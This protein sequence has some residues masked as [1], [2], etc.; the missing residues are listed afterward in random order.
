M[1]KILTIVLSVLIFLAAAFIGVANV[2]RVDGVVLDAKTVSEEAKIEAKQMQVELE[3][4]Y[5]GESSLF[6]KNEAALAV[7]EKYPYFRLTK[8][9]KRYPD[10]LYVE[11]TEDP[12]V[13]A[14]EADGEYY[15]LSENGTVLD[16][17]EEKL[18]RADGQPNVIVKG[19]VPQGGIGD[20]VSGD[21]LSELL[22]MCSLMARNLNGVRSNVAEVRFD[23][24][25][26][27]GRIFLCMREGVQITVY[28][29]QLLTEEKAV[30]FT[31]KYLSLDD[32]EKLTGFIH[33]TE[34]LDKT[35]VIISYRPNTLG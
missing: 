6:A 20:T 29:P 11:A 17:R 5:R 7:I 1:K 30:A 14:V 34:S 26:N 4:A 27:G 24:V 18:N 2:Y 23:D 33:V 21:G 12:E 10:V 31:E 28:N 3:E 32:E 35:Q 19:A 9:E 15:I 22:Q 16:I 25:G 13:F 8:F